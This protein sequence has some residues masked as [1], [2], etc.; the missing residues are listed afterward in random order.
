MKSSAKEA[1]RKVHQE[2]N[3]AVQKLST[4]ERAL[5]G[6]E[7]ECA[8]LRDQL[9]KTQQ[10]FQEVTSMLS[11]LEEKNYELSVQNQTYAMRE[12]QQDEEIHGLY[13]Q[14]KDKSIECL[15]LKMV[16]EGVIK[17]LHDLMERIELYEKVNISSDDGAEEPPIPTNSKVVMRWLE[18]D[19]EIYSALCNVSQKVSNLY[20]CFCSKIK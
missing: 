11:V 20:T 10:N 3:E 7:D 12:L 5:C 8:L 15:N 4:I 17:K 9:L 13:E 18:G 16:N 1:L 19:S 6:S 14:V 2:R